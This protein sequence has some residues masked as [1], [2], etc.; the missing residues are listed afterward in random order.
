MVAAISAATVK[1]GVEDWCCREKFP[2]FIV[3][4]VPDPKT[5]FF[6][7]FRVRRPFDYLAHSLQE[8]VL[9]KTNGTD[10]KPRL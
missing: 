8:T 5:A 6:S 3:W 9:P 10:G 7:R 4:A 1:R 2:N